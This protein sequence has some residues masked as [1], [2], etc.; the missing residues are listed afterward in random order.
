MWYGVKFQHFVI[1]IMG[2]FEAITSD[3]TKPAAQ[4]PVTENSS[5]GILNR[6]NISAE[7]GFRV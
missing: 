3:T 4:R 7:L 1:S 5:C 6:G 2:L